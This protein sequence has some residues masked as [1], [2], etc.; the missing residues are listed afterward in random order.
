MNTY[1]YIMNNLMSDVL[2]GFTALI[3]IINPIGVA[4][5]FYDRTVD[6]DEKARRLIAWRVAINS[7]F[8]LL[9]AFFAGAPVL[10]FFGISIEALR[11]G[12]GFAVAVAGWQMLTAPE[13]QHPLSHTHRHARLSPG[14]AASKAFFPLTIPLTTGPGCITAAIALSANRAAHSV[15]AFLEAAV[16]SI[17][18]SVLVMIVIYV[19]YSRADRLADYL[20]VQGTRVAVRVSSFLLLCIGVQIMLT[21]IAGFLGPLIKSTNTAS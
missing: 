10:R 2:F 8:V 17:T 5:V 11:I 13:P 15:S 19:V 4:F 12:G 9:V 16:S 18:I 7:F 21:G 14:E 20:G 1:L 6:F 3:S